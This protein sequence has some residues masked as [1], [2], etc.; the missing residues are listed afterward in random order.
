ME[1]KEWAQQRAYGCRPLMNR[2]QTICIFGWII[3]TFFN[4]FAAKKQSVDNQIILMNDSRIMIA[5]IEPTNDRID[6]SR[7]SEG[8]EPSIKQK[9]ANQSYRLQRWS[10]DSSVFEPN[11]SANR[12]NRDSPFELSQL[13]MAQNSD[14]LLVSPLISLPLSDQWI[15]CLAKIR[16]QFFS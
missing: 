2:W 3:L 12:T 15:I 4:S 5:L 8:Y 10:D 6:K 9:T 11:L 16:I 14:P 7:V 13:A 1:S